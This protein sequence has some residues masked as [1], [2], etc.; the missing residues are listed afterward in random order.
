MCSQYPYNIA[1]AKL[2][3]GEYLRKYPLTRHYA[4]PCLLAYS[5]VVMALLPY[6]RDFCNG[7]ISEG[8][9]CADGQC[10]ESKPVNK[11]VFRKIAGFKPHAAKLTLKRINAFLP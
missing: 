10:I 2:S 11:D 8:K 6:L 1:G 9:L 7:V 3:A 4:V 5:A